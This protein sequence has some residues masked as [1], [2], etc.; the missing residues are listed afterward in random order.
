[1]RVPAEARVD[2]DAIAGN[3]G[4]LRE[5]SIA[6]Q[7]LFTGV[8]AMWEHALTQRIALRAHV[9]ADVLLTTTDLQ[10]DHMSVWR[11]PRI[12]GAAGLGIVVQFP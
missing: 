5:R 11:S 1:M 10:V 2:L 12:D 6:S 4:L 3:A 9:Q 7:V 8:A